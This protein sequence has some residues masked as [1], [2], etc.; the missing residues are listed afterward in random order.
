VTRLKGTEA[1]FVGEFV[2]EKRPGTYACVCCGERLFASDAKYESGS[3]W[4]SFFAAL[5]DAAITTEEDASHSMVRTEILCAQCDAHLGHLFPDGPEP[6]GL[7]FCVN[8][9]SLSFEPK[10]ASE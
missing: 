3:G 6:T 7:R 2:Y 9:A 10:E 4:P 1:P 8:S 5:S